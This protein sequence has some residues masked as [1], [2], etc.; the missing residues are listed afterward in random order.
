M[1]NFAQLRELILEA[2]GLGYEIT[3]NG[4]EL[5]GFVLDEEFGIK[6]WWHYLF[7]ALTITQQ[8]ELQESCKTQIPSSLR[9]FLSHSN[10]VNLFS[11]ALCIYG[12]RLGND[13]TSKEAYPYAMD[14]PNTF[15]RPEDAKPNHLF[16]GG[17]NWDGT[18]LYMDTETG[19]V[20]RCQKRTVKPINEWPDFWTMLL[21]EAKR[22]KS[23]FAPSG[24]KLDLSAPTSPDS[25]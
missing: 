7:P 15:E 6:R 24:S 4:A 25:V 22:I 20:Y 8:D 9:E 18:L 16:I 5:F 13:R 11:D 10:G 12:L 2:K 1:T 3:P 19:K 23:L 21:S 14:I 17:F